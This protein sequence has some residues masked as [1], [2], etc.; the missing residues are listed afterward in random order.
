MTVIEE[1][2]VA[3]LRENSSIAALVGD[4]IMPLVLDQDPSL[5]ALVYQRVD[6]PREGSQDGPSG[7]AHPRIQFSCWDET[8]LGALTLASA[9]RIALDGFR[10]TM[11]GRLISGIK[12]VNDLDD[13]DSMTGRYR[14]IVDAIVWHREEVA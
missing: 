11:S 12:I 8:H 5:P 6:G 13:Y 4:D 3:Y 2:L 7:L 10:G 1:D 14:V 9:L